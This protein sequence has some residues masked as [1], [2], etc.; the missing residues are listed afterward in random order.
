MAIKTGKI[1]TYLSLFHI[2][3]IA[4]SQRHQAFIDT[5]HCFVSQYFVLLLLIFIL[6]IAAGIFAYVKKDKVG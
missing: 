3:I 4:E 6:E 5:Y 2:V 1:C